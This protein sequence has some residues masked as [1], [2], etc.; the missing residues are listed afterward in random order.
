MNKLIVYTTAIILALSL[1]AQT[2]FARGHGHGEKMSG[3][4]QMM[5][6]LELTKEQKEKLTELR[7]GQKEKRKALKEK[8]KK[9]G[10]E[11]RAKIQSEA[12]DEE[13]RKSHSAMQSLMM[14]MGSLRMDSMLS[15]RKVLTKEQKE[16]FKSM[17][18]DVPGHSSHMG[19]GMGDN[20]SED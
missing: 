7:K 12:S 20:D 16:K 13:I 8:L 14:E 15:L 4:K 17:H 6:D 9:A 19:Y 5:K 11:F 2:S 10:E 1:S 3:R 18:K